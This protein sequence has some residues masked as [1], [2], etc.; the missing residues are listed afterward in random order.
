MISRRCA[1][2][3]SCAAWMAAWSTVME[4]LRFT[5]YAAENDM[6]DSRMRWAWFNPCLNSLFPA[7]FVDV[8]FGLVAARGV[9]GRIVERVKTRV[10]RDVDDAVGHDRRGIDP[11]PKVRFAQHLLLLG[12]RQH[13]EIP[14]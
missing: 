6:L 13:H 10:A 3:F 2:S 4:N 1:S 7:G 9:P 11:R 5:I 12:R 14:V 8:H